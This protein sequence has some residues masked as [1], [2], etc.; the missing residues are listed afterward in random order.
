MVSLSN[1]VV[2]AFDLPIIY[3][4]AR[5]I[6]NEMPEDDNDLF[7]PGDLQGNIKIVNLRYQYKLD[8]PFVL[9]NLNGLEELLEYNLFL[10]INKI[11]II[12][13]KNL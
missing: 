13:I 5:P 12:F 7:D 8:C 3:E 9:D 11:Y 2:G 1:L 4:R 6:L 10:N